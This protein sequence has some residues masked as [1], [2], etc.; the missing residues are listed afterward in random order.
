MTAQLLTAA[1]CT[2]KHDMLDRAAQIGD[3]RTLTYLKV[4]SSPTGCGRGARKDCYP[5]L[6]RDDA[7]KNAIAA[8]DSRFGKKTR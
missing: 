8:L 2:D 5:C 6:R 3:E 1:K 4:L 7:L